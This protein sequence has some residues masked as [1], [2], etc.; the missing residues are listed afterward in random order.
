[1]NPTGQLFRRLSRLRGKR[2][3]HPFGV[4]FAARLT[5]LG[6]GGAGAAMF[7]R[8]A[9]A[10]VRLSRSFGLPEWAPDPC[11]LAFRVPDAYGPG[12]HQDLLLVS[13]AAPPGGRHTLLPSRGFCDRPYSCVLPYRLRGE[14]VMIGARA[15]APGPGP[16]LRDLAERE[17]G[18]LEFEL[19]V[20]GL[21]DEW[22]PAAR[23]TLGE[24]LPSERTERLDLD[25]TN[26]GGGLEPAGLLNRLRGPA[27]AGSQAG[28]EAAYRQHG[29]PERRNP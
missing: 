24:R 2:V 8:E 13:S 3:F 4:G 20:A 17:V 23:L 29:L 12:R 9:E 25:P 26:C 15:S 5:P 6:E 14:T 21:K 22:R 28:R 18:G 10:Q 27:Y 16:K 11:G 19:A 1:M 7:E